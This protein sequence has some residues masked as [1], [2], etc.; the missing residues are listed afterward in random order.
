MLKTN[1]INQ[2]NITDG[3]VKILSVVGGVMAGDGIQAVMPAKIQSSSDAIL[4]VAGATGAVVL[5]DSSTMGTVAK[6][7][8]LGLAVKSFY[9]IMSEQLQ[10][11]LPAKEEGA[12]LSMIDKFTRGAVGLSS[13]DSYGSYLAS[14]MI[15]FD[16]YEEVEPQRTASGSSF[17]S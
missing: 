6:Y 8:S 1:K 9:G 17:L 3:A 5:K 7:A 10:K 13:P 4:S 11:A 16:D 2:K 15:N 14:P 12:E